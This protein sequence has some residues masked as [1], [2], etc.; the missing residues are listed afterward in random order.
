MTAAKI[1]AE[2]ASDPQGSAAGARSEA[3]ATAPSEVGSERGEREAAD[4][5]RA[6]LASPTFTGRPTTTTPG[7][8]DNSTRIPSTAYVKALIKAVEEEAVVP[9]GAK[10]TNTLLL[11]NSEGHVEYLAPPTVPGEVL[12]LNSLGALEWYTPRIFDVTAYGAKGDG[13]TDCHEAV[14]KAIEAATYTNDQTILYFP[15]AEPGKKYV[16]S[17]NWTLPGGQTVVHV[18]GSGQ[19]GRIAL[20]TDLTF[21]EFLFQVSETEATGQ[22]GYRMFENLVIEGPRTWPLAPNKKEYKGYFPCYAM[23]F[24]VASSTQLVNCEANGFYACFVI[25]G[26]NHRLYNITAGTCLYGVYVGPNK[27]KEGTERGGWYMQNARI[28][29]T[30]AAIG[31]SAV[32]SCEGGIW[33]E[34]NS[35]RSPYVLY[36]EAPWGLAQSFAQAMTGIGAPNAEECG[37]AHFFDEGRDL[38]SELEPGAE[39]ACSG[40]FLSMNIDF[41][42]A[43]AVGNMQALTISATGG[44]FKLKLPANTTTGQTE[45]TTAAI[46]PTESNA[47]IESKIRSAL[48]K[49][50]VVVWTNGEGKKAIMLIGYASL[51]STSKMTIVENVVTGGAVEIS[52]P[53]I[54][55][56]M[57]PLFKPSANTKKLTVEKATGGTFKLVIK[58]GATEY[59]TGT[60]KY[61]AS[62]GE[63]QEKINEAIGVWTSIVADASGPY[64]ITFVGARLFEAPTLTANTEGLTG[65]GA[66]V[67]IAAGPA[68]TMPNR[69]AEYTF[70]TN[71][72]SISLRGRAPGSSM[73]SG[74][75][76]IFRNMPEG[77]DATGVIVEAIL[78]IAGEGKLIVGAEKNISQTITLECP[79]GTYTLCYITTTGTLAKG[80]LLAVKPSTDGAKNEVE[81]YPAT[82][83]AS[84]RAHAGYAAI[85]VSGVK[86]QVIPVLTRCVQGYGSYGASGAP[87]TGTAP[88]PAKLL[89]PSSTTAGAV[90]EMKKEGSLIVGVANS[91]GSGGTVIVTPRGLA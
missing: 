63:M 34:V 22:V 16:T 68:V 12:R 1:A 14:Q 9:V 45:A 53:A 71:R 37:N 85:E 29:A 56:N 24:E 5:L 49:G 39:G 15:P 31:V 32:T 17:R 47:N 18:R 7:S 82:G 11:V 38:N 88:E 19:T 28:S 75:V 55:S 60:I 73:G 58:W 52:E 13:A 25:R 10:L 80:S 50:S 65:T 3:E 54:D 69:H 33:T 4:A 57:G 6:P 8:T 72:L 67:A 84:Y 26:T 86:S 91:K 46:S 70:D 48:N 87:Y 51:W 35:E 20:T 83:A 2:A 36:K 44:T 90:E 61:N 27:L 89:T 42:H 79:T 43:N 30:W 66:A 21:S 78:K 40:T 59:E 62:A 81:I 77:L 64:I 41:N 74:T 23:G 76:G